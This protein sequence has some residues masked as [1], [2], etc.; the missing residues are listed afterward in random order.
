[1]PDV[2]RFV[3]QTGFCTSVWVPASAGTTERGEPTHKLI[4]EEQAVASIPTH[5][6]FLAKVPWR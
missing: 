4:P 3:W 5:E 1:V 2:P 6:A